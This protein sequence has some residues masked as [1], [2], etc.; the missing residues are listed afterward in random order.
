MIDVICDHLQF[1][2]PA[3]GKGKLTTQNWKNEGMF[4]AI[5]QRIAMLQ[6]DAIAQPGISSIK[7]DITKI[8]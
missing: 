5:R 7:S 8:A 3:G 4:A 2:C 6:E 1:Q